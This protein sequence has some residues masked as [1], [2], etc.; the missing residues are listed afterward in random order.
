MPQVLLAPEDMVKMS[1]SVENGRRGAA[2]VYLIGLSRMLS[3][4]RRRV[5]VYRA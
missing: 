1:E 3:P 4:W 2:S 5:K